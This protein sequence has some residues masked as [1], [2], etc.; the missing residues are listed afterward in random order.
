[1]ARRTS[2]ELEKLV[3][4]V[5]RWRAQ[6]GGRRSRIPEELWQEAVLAARGV[7]VWAA[8]KA[9]RFNYQ[10]LRRRVELENGG[11][12]GTPR[13]PSGG[14][15]LV[16]KTSGRS[17]IGMAGGAGRATTAGRLRRS[18]GRPVKE[19]A[20]SDFIAL[21]V[22]QLSGVRRTV[23]DLESRHG[24]RIRFE[25]AGGVDIVGLVQRLWSGQ[26]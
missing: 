9:L 14:R 25:V 13:T 3:E 17:K 21:E 22:G 7:G 4:Q 5:T 11:S 18:S 16:A 26:P 2:G 20:V 15:G 8:A 6:E 10:A 12:E 1:M 19:K 23:I 24:D